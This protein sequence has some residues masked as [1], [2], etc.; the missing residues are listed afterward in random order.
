VAAEED[1]VLGRLEEF[2]GIPTV[3]GNAAGLRDGAEWL[4]RRLESIGFSTKVSAG[5]RAPFVLGRLDRARD[6]TLAIY[7]MYD[8]LAGRPSDAQQDS[9]GLS[10]KGRDVATRPRIGNKA[11]IELFLTAVEELRGD[12][13]CPSVV[14]IAE[15]AELDGSPGLEAAIA[16]EPDLWSEA[17]SAFW[18]RASQSRDGPATINLAYRGMLGLTL[19]V[20]TSGSDEGDSGISLHT[21]YRPWVDSPTSVLIDALG[22]LTK[23]D[24]NDLAFDLP[25]SSWQLPPAP[26]SFEPGRVLAELGVGP[27]ASLSKDGLWR[28]LAE[29]SVNVELLGSPGPGVGLIQPRAAARVQFRLP[30][31]MLTSLVLERIRS[32]LD[33]GGW[34]RVAIEVD[35]AITGASTAPDAAIVLATEDMYVGHGVSVERWP[36]STATAPTCAF[37]ALGLNIGDGG[38]GS[39]DPRSTRLSI[40]DDGPIAGVGR[41]IAGYG[42]L[43][44]SFARR[45]SARLSPPARDSVVASAGR[46]AP[47]AGRVDA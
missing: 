45:S 17:T 26:P 30:P 8:T 47:E 5:P 40:E 29:V 9:A 14:F 25:P 20:T 32:H 1:Q 4:R 46:S 6:A 2:V 43:L 16:T 22:S 15:G 44:R 34:G 36:I 28:R 23:S 41:T 11:A 39:R 31:R 7:G 18:P 38:L 24:G 12:P 3:A 33:A 13:E 42:T 10:L 19:S 21:Q 27:N 37:G 35:Y